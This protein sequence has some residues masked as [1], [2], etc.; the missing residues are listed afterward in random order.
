MCQAMVDSYNS[1]KKG[2]FAELELL[3]AIKVK[4]TEHFAKM[5]VDTKD[6]KKFVPKKK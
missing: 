3:D 1:A 5:A 6:F 2:R 4:V